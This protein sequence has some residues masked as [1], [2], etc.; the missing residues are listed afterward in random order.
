M[1]GTLVVAGEELRAAHHQATGFADRQRLA[2]DVDDPDVDAFE[3]P[4]V[5]GRRFLGS[6]RRLGQRAR[7]RLGHAP[8]RAHL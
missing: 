1:V 5:G 8:E 7:Q 6:A 2:V 4:A 3:R